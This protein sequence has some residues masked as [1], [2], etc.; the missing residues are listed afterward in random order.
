MNRPAKMNAF[1]PEMLDSL[2]SALQT[3]TDD[4]TCHVLVLTG[5]GRGFCA[6]ADLSGDRGAGLS[7]AQQR[8][9]LRGRAEAIELFR[10]LPMPSI[11]VINGACAGLGLALA[12]TC[13]LRIAVDTAVFNT[14]YLSAGLSG[15]FAGMHFLRQVIGGGRALDWYLRPR[16]IPAAEALQAGFLSISAAP[17]QFDVTAEEIVTSLATSAPLAV[18][19]I[20]ANYADTG[21]FDLSGYLDRESTRHVATRNTCDAREAAAAFLSKRDP[22]FRGE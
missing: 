17:D 6:G 10:A 22:I 18:R 14:A 2:V 20:R 15:D 1:T 19:A 5:A 21:D 3:L 12:A 4:T 11:A 9:A 8:G 16:K 7:V 13:D